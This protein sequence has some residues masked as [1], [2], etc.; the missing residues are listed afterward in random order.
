MHILICMSHMIFQ[1][2]MRT[3]RP[4]ELAVIKV[5]LQAGFNVLQR[6]KVLSLGNF[7]TGP[8]LISSKTGR[9]FCTVPA[10]WV[11]Q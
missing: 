11:F 8:H 1:P 2:H 6:L 7:Q 3:E 5:V 10:L 9:S 4:T